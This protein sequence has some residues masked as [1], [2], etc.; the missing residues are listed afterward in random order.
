MSGTS[1]SAPAGLL[2]LV[3]SCSN[4]VFRHVS[5]QGLHGLVARLCIL[6]RLWS[7]SL[8]GIGRL[9]ACVPCRQPVL[10]A[11]FPLLL[12]SLCMV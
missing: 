7:T 8:W 1:G 3:A 12:C 10:L 5:E 11:I 6:S 9:L 2:M 4:R